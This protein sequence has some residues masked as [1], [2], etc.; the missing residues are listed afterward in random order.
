MNTLF[1]L[2]STIFDDIIFCPFCKMPIEYAEGILVDQSV[3]NC[4]I[5]CNNVNCNVEQMVVCLSADYDSNSRFLFNHDPITDGCFSELTGDALF[6]YCDNMQIDLEYLGK[7]Q[8]LKFYKVYMVLITGVPKCFIKM[9]TGRSQ[10]HPYLGWTPHTVP[11]S[12]DEIIHWVKL[13]TGVYDISSLPE[14][15]YVNDKF[16][17]QGYCAHCEVETKSLFKS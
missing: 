4:V 11:K 8:G 16:F 9:P 10:H 5:C 12:L 6:D 1:T 2:G 13:K 17:Y 7:N 14:H 15:V 3:G